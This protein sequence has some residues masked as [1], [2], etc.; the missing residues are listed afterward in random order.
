MN[1][2]EETMQRKKEVFKMDEK[3]IKT[4][5]I[6]FENCEV[7]SLTPDMINSF[8]VE[9]VYR[10]IGIN[11]FQYE[12]GEVYEDLTCKNSFISINKKGMEADGGFNDMPLGERLKENDITHYDIIYED[13]TS[14]YIGV[15][16]EDRNGNEFKN[17]LQATLY[18]GH[19]WKDEKNMVVFINEKPLT[20]GDLEDKYGIS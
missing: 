17:K 3:K 18:K 2:V 20:L 19:F 10:S 1:G 9:D 7:Y 11:L 15:P 13:G 16:W 8:L 6:V 5:N 14:D 4:L 12:E